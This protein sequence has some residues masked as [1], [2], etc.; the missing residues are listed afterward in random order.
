MQ[1]EGKVNVLLVD[2]RPEKLLALEAV[3]VE[4]DVNLVKALS[5]KEALRRILANEEFAVILLDVN[6]PGMDGFETATLIR[7]RKN[8]AD[9]PIIFVTAFSDEMHMSRGYSLGAVDYI[10]API[11]PEVLKTKVGV[12]VELYRK[13]Q[14]VSRQ[15]QWLHKRAAQLYKLTAASLQINSALSMEMLLS[16]VTERAREI[17]GCHQASTILRLEPAWSR[18]R[19]VVSLSDK[20]Q[21][22]RDRRSRLDDSGIHAMVCRLNKPIRMTHPELTEHPAWE[23]IQRESEDR[24]PLRGIMAAPLSGRDGRNMGLVQLSEKIE[25]EFTE[26]DQAILVQLAQMAS[27]AIENNLFSEAKEANRIKDEFLATLSHELRTPLNATLGWTRLLRMGKLEPPDIEHGLEVIER[28]V[29]AQAKLIEDLLDVS[30]I[31]TGKLRLSFQTVDLK[32]V[33]EAA[34]DVVKPAAA[35]KQIEIVADLPEPIESMQG[36]P[37]RLQQVI[38]NLLTNAVKFTPAQGRVEVA[39]GCAGGHL[40]VRIK[41]NGKGIS[42]AFLPH[43][44]ERFR[45]ADS[46][47]TRSQGGLGIG[48]AIVRHVIEL[49]GGTVA[50]QSEGEG[51]GATFIVTLPILAARIDG[52]PAGPRRSAAPRESGADLSSLRVLVV[53]DESDAREMLAH[54]LRRAGATVAAASSAREA[55]EL[56]DAGPADV[57]ICDIAMPDQD[58]YWLV[59]ALRERGMGLPV[60]ALTAY[61]REEDRARAISAGFD[62]HC[63]KPIEPMELVAAV[64]DLARRS[65]HAPALA[66]AA[67]K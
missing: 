44:F 63:A 19:Q 20:Y 37:D 2:D 32:G 25:G 66:Q 33:V 24:P 30:R 9:T 6:M 17:V 61:A 22:F 59:R 39:L 13:T 26:D 16:V 8:S 21:A 40:Q 47:S 5:G 1:H 42:P 50:A 38:W 28:N 35:A 45:Q 10:L 34:I 62:L 54:M 14:Q 67:V 48:L 11:V 36:D 60:I 46:T 64:A 23:N 65:L 31:I 53:D 7:Q 58:G 18:A 41:D 51:R 52:E 29:N 12:F 55:L 15:A 56:I 27:I 3:L 43:V 57:I 4:L 49:H